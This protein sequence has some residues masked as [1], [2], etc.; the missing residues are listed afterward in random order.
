MMAASTLFSAIITTSHPCQTYI[1][2]LSEYF[3]YSDTTN[4]PAFLSSPLPTSTMCYLLQ[5][6]Q[7]LTMLHTH[8]MSQANHIAHAPVLEVMGLSFHKDLG[9]FESASFGILQSTS[10][11]VMCSCLSLYKYSSLLYIFHYFE[12]QLSNLLL[13]TRSRLP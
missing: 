3:F 5:H 6:N 2:A 12:N 8:S 13:L 10:L 7:S 1:G 9:G 4:K 11:F